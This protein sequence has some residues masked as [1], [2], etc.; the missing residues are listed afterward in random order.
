MRSKDKEQRSPSKEYT[1]ADFDLLFHPP[2][3]STI[4]TFR[5]WCTL[6]CETLEEFPGII[7]RS[8]SLMKCMCGD[9]QHEFLN[10]E[11]ENTETK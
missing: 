8:L 6:L 9:F 11:V 5:H 3:T 4:T 2:T 7:V 10:L 1:E